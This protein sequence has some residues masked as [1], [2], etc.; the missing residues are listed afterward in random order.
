MRA[1]MDRRH[2]AL[3]LVL[4][5]VCFACATVLPSVSAAFTGSTS[6]PSSFASTSWPAT[7]W[8]G[9]GSSGQGGVLDLPSRWTPHAATV[10]NG[11]TFTSVDGMGGRF[12]GIAADSSV[13][14]WGDNSNTQ[15]S[16]GSANP[17]PVPAAVQSLPTG[18][19]WSQIAVSSTT[20]CAIRSDPGHVGE[21]WCWGAGVYG[22]LGTGG[23]PSLSAPVRV[24]SG[25]W[26]SVAASNKTFCAISSV[27]QLFCWGGDDA[28][29][30]GIGSTTTTVSSP[31]A[32]SGTSATWSSVAG[33]TEHL[34]GIRTDG[35]AWCWG[36]GASGRLGNGATSN[37]NVPVAVGGSPTGTA[38]ST[39]APLGEASC[40][41]RN[42]HT[43]WCWGSDYYGELG[44]G[45]SS[46]SHNTS[47]PVRS[48]SSS[49]WNSL[50]AGGQG[51][52]AVDSSSKLYC[53]GGNSIG[54][55]GVGSRTGS[56]TPP[57]LVTGTWSAVA[58]SIDSA[59]ALTGTG[60]VWCWGN[61]GTGQLGWG[62]AGNGTTL[63][64]L[65]N[66]PQ[67]VLTL[68][69]GSSHS[70]AVAYGT[71]ALYCWGENGSGQL[72]V[73]DS[74]IRS[75][76]TQV[77]TATDWF[78][79][80]GG[81]RHTCGI[82]AVTPG[83]GTLWCWGDNYAGA[84]GQSSS[85]TVPKQVGT[86]S[87]WTAVTTG[88]SSSC[89]LRN[90]GQ[91]WCFGY[92]NVGQLG[93]G[94]TT[95]R[96]APVQVGSATWIG[97]SL[98]TSHACGIQTGG[99]LYCWGSAANG[100]LGNG[101]TTAS[102]TS[103]VAV[104]TGSG[105][106]STWSQVDAGNSHTCAIAADSTAWCWGAGGNGALGTGS[107]AD[108]TVPAPVST[109]TG[110]STWTTV[111]AAFSFTCGIATDQ[112]AWCWGSNGNG[113]LGIAGGDRTTPGQLPVHA[114]TA[115]QGGFLHTLLAG[116]PGLS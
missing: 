2:A 82:R 83:A 22:Q 13:W 44:D 65:L 106:P 31:T 49:S 55:V 32:V 96:A 75:F 20:Q 12:C 85:S 98:G 27:A 3:A 47:T 25:S 116:N 74:T 11:Q 88:D 64:V 103:P 38:W 33:G 42:D 58:V 54:Q 113:Q 1:T 60:Q 84:I 97:V 48:G 69:A 29:Q 77:G 105:R 76:A 95:A 26:G 46:S 14:C 79:V 72:G 37:S 7:L 43:I 6:N 81:G 90:G 80:S 73:G 35:T 5:L 45:T 115:V 99:V 100:R 102:S 70:C 87:D 101:S 107:S 112:H 114:V 111:V 23:S 50:G 56:V 34:C 16:T 17:Q 91:L 71:Q 52:C 19:T 36:N 53:W 51:A 30:A 41:L 39:L 21:L 86:A 9:D 104:S 10:A 28:G 40:G 62:T 108:S 18:S 15:L 94:D 92:N 59:C 78:A 109:S 61:N 4:L 57:A 110:A 8:I 67:R 66:A 24:G 63:P 68:G 93:L 89:G